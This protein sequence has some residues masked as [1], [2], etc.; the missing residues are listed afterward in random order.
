MRIHSLMIITAGKKWLTK[1]DMRIA[2]TI[3]TS[4]ASESQTYMYV[5]EH[6]KCGRAP[7]TK[8]SE[9]DAVIWGP[10]TRVTMSNP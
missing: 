7:L 10:I 6:R 1:I 8:T 9:A 2:M 4:A 3:S 5:R